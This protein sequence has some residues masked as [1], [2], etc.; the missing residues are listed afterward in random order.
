MTVPRPPSTSLIELGPLAAFGP[1]IEIYTISF[2]TDS[3]GIAPLAFVGLQL[4]DGT[5][6]NF[7]ASVITRANSSVSPENPN[8]DKKLGH[9]GDRM[10]R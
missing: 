7:S 1:Y 10:K 4:T 2:P 8:T 9:P 5:K 6:W 3:D